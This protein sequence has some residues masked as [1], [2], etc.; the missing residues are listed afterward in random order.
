VLFSGST[1]QSTAGA[2][3]RIA[4]SCLDS[5]G[6]G[7][8]QAQTHTQVCSMFGSFTGAAGHLVCL[9]KARKRECKRE[10]EGTGT[11]I[12]CCSKHTVCY[13]NTLVHSTYTLVGQSMNIPKLH[14]CLSGH[15]AYLVVM[16][17]SKV[18]ELLVK[19]KQGPHLIS[20][21]CALKCGEVCHTSH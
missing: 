13:L 7:A 19:S 20:G 15:P 9:R 21:G 17:G 12:V 1:Q 5:C 4:V 14:T 11:L 2:G 16:R 18:F 8:E 3:G 10:E 6:S